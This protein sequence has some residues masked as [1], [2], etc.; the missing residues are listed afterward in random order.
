MLGELLQ[1][2]GRF[3]FGLASVGVRRP[4]LNLNTFAYFPPETLLVES[5]SEIATQSSLPL[6]ESVFVV[7]H[8]NC[9]ARPTIDLANLMPQDDDELVRALLWR[10]QLRPSDTCYFSAKG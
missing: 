7:F 9:A 10:G 3:S 4:E 1:S 2:R 6:P 5:H 8:R